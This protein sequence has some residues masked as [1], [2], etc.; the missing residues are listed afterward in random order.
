MSEFPKKTAGALAVAGIVAFGAYRCIKKYFEKKA[1]VAVPVAEVDTAHAELKAAVEQWIEYDPNPQSK[2]EVEALYAAGEYEKLQALFIPR[3]AFGTAGLRSRMDKGYKNMNE[4]V[5]LQATQGLCR[6]MLETVE[7][8]KERGVII[9]YDGRYNSKTFAH[10]AAAVLIS[11]GVKVF[12]FNDY[13]CTPLVPFGVINKGAAAGIMVTASH[14]PKDDNGYKVYWSNGAQI[15]PPTDSGIAASILDNLKPWEKYSLDAASPLL[16]DATDEITDAYFASIREKCCFHADTNADAKMKVTYTAMH[17]VGAKFVTR[18]FQTFN[19]PAF[20]PTE[21]QLLPDPEFPTVAFPNPEEGKGAL[22]LAMEAADN[23]GSNLILANDPDADRLAVA[24]RDATSG[25]WVILTGNEIAAVFADWTWLKWREAHPED[26]ASKCVMIA[27]TVSSKHLKAMAET[28]GFEFRDTLTGFKWMGNEAIK[29]VNDGYTCLLAYEVE[30]GFL[31]GDTSFD[32]DGVRT[33]AAFY[34]CANYWN[35][36]GQTVLDRVRAFYE[37]Y[38]HFKM[39][40][41]YFFCD[42]AAKF[43]SVFGQLRNAQGDDVITTYDGAVRY[44]G[45]CGKYKI[46]SVRDV[47]CG[48]DTK[49][50]DGKLVLPQMTDAHM[51]TF[52][53]ENGATA[54]MRN[55]GTEPKLKYYVECCSKESPEAAEALLADMTKELIENF[56]VPSKYNLIP[57][58]E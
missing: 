27:S 14:N 8:A 47:S 33:A 1:D 38:G 15:I 36:R 53:F 54:T 13:V 18:A 22:K 48:Y 46:A 4:L 45:S 2:R 43:E 49:Q 31:I 44:P 35:E 11:A 26:D 5:V 19:L 52:T 30:I 6:Y 25:Q 20:V 24:C 55:S 51:L 7:N 42:N 28:E 40:N 37:R 58:K 50:A 16:V 17:G 34:E 32:K 9:G 29:A 23:S 39:V 3:I 12:L 41:S 10:L 56:I 57:K 21:A